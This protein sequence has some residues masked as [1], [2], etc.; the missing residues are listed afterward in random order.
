ML[1]ADLDRFLSHRQS[2]YSHTLY[3]QNPP[4]LEAATSQNNRLLV[5]RKV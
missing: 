1:H 2:I 4:D 3:S 5:D